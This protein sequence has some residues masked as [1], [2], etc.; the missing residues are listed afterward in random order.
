MDDGRSQRRKRREEKERLKKLED[1]VR[2]ISQDQV[3][4]LTLSFYETA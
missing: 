1:E 4:I 2:P 3:A